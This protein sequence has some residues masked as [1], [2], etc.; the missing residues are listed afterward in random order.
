M[1]KRSIIFP[2]VSV[3]HSILLVLFTFFFP[4]AQFLKESFMLYASTVTLPVHFPEQYNL[5]SSLIA[6]LKFPQ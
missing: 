2:L 5:G 4:F 3:H 1:S 6:R